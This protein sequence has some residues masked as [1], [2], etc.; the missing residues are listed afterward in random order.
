MDIPPPVDCKGV[1]R[2]L[3][4]VNFL[5]KFVPHMSVVIEPVRSLLRKD[6]KFMWSNVQGKAFNKMKDVL[7]QQPVL[8]PFMLKSL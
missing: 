3:G 1:E 5:A 2:L 6:V 8:K 4:T 7:S